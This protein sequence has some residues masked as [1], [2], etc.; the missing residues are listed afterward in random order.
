MSQ[1]RPLLA[2]AVLCLVS[3]PPAAALELTR[4]APLDKNN[5]EVVFAYQGDAVLTQTGIDG[6]FSKLPEAHRLVFIRDGAQVDRLVR[7]IM[8]SK[9][10]ALDAIE[11]G[12]LEDPIVR[13]R[14]I[15]AAHKELAEAWIAQIKKNAPEADYEAMAYEDYLANPDDYRTPEYIDVTHILIGTKERSDEEALELALSVR[16]KA[17][18]APESFSELVKEYSDDP[19]KVKNAGSYL[20]VGRGKMAKPF[21]D[22]AFALESEGDISTPVGT[23]YGYHIIRLDKRY[24]P[25]P[26]AFEDVRQEAV[27]E[28]KEKHQN[29]YRETYI[30]ALLADG[31]VLPEGS[32]QV[33][34]ERHFGENLENAPQY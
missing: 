12:L 22:A 31:I 17:L 20:R 27:A 26:R 7:N 24:A 4:E 28:M 6:A 11:N 30:K 5:P 34:L 3:T 1:L 16:E 14:V 9:V 8:K 23:D 18:E 13:E 2:L 21:E 19:A 33:M 15:Q 29:K 10:L 25:R 32:V